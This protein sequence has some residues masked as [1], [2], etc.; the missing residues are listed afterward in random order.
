MLTVSIYNDQ[1]GIFDA[2]PVTH[3]NHY[4]GFS[5]W[6][7]FPMI[8]KDSAPGSHLMDASPDRRFDAIANRKMS[9]FLSD[10]VSLCD[11]WEVYHG[12]VDRLNKEGVHYSGSIANIFGV[13]MTSDMDA[14]TC[15]SCKK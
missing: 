11:V 6:D 2:M 1:T 12:T 15:L 8:S 3:Q 4:I 13:N 5:S 14:V 10:Y 7:M 9:G